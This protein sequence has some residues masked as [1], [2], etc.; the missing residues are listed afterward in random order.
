MNDLDYVMLYLRSKERDDIL[1]LA[2]HMAMA[3]RYDG[4][5]MHYQAGL[6]W[7]KYRNAV[8]TVHATSAMTER[9]HNIAKDNTIKDLSFDELYDRL[10]K[11]PARTAVRRMHPVGAPFRG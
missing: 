1:L 9:A 10:I 8:H 6:R 5:G 2:Y 7:S 3:Y 4:L 11:A